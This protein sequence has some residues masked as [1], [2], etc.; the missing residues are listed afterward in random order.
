MADILKI[1]SQ[2]LAASSL[3]K[4]YEVPERSQASITSISICNQNSSDVTVDIALFDNNVDISSPVAKNYV[5]K[6]FGVEANSTQLISPGFTL[7]QRNVIAVNCSTA[8]NVGVNIF[9]IET[10]R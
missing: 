9:G 7:D 10:T 5:F 6:T 8:S 1:L 4:V 2:S 3:T